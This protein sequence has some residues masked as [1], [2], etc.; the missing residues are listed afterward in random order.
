MAEEKR[1]EDKPLHWIS[2]SRKDIRKMP[3]DVKDIFGFALREA[4]SGNMHPDARVMKGFGGAGVLGVIADEKGN[5][6]RAIYT[7]RFPSAV[8]ALHVFQ[9][10]SKKGIETPKQEIELVKRRLKM[11]EYHHKE[12]YEQKKDTTSR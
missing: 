11:A 12:H 5:T 1:E 7:A 2:S 6:Y 4:Q 3:E 8:Y 9:K 10:K